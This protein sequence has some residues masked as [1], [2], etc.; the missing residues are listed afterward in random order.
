MLDCEL[1]CVEGFLEASGYSGITRES[2]D[3]IKKEY[4]ELAQQ[5]TNKQSEPFDVQPCCQDNEWLC[6]VCGKSARFY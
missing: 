3:R 2:W 5:T 4:K 1:N 6:S